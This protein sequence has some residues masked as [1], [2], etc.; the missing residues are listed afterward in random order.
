MFGQLKDL[1]NLR[2][3]AQELQ[4]QLENEKVIG[5]SN[6]GLVTVTINGNHEVL[7]V[8]IH[9]ER[10]L[11]SSKL[12]SAFKNAHKNAL[13]ELKSNLSKKFAGMM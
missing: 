6:D 9:S 7:D 11:N 4:K 10:E 2:K 8:K 5:T 12:E 3:Q 13:D 1:Y